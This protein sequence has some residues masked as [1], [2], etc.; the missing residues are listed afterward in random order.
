[1]ALRL[2][3]YFQTDTDRNSFSR[4]IVQA[5]QPLSDPS[6]DK[7]FLNKFGAYEERKRRLDEE[8]RQDFLKLQAEVGS[9][10]LFKTIINLTY[11]TIRNF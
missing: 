4:P 9:F 1:M 11:I 8:R 5:T 2:Y 6:D 7:G 3:F 10:C